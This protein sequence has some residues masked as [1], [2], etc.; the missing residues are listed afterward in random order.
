LLASNIIVLHDAIYF[1]EIIFNWLE[2]L[3]FRSSLPCKQ[4]SRVFPQSLNCSSNIFIDF[5]IF[6]NLWQ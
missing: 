4:K 2:N 5:C 3:K 6:I 1:V